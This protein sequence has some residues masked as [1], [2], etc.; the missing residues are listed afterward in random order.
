MGLDLWPPTP[1]S[2]VLTTRPHSDIGGYLAGGMV[3]I[4]LLENGF[5]TEWSARSQA[6]DGEEKRA[7]FPL[8]AHVLNS[9]GILP[10]SSL[11]RAWE[12]G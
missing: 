3:L 8:F 11:S 1:Q 9:G 10:F 5:V 7:W 2:S 6:Q 4:D 12:R